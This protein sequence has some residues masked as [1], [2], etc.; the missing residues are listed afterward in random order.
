[1]TPTRSTT[2]NRTVPTARPVMKQ[3]A[4][5]AGVA[6]SSVS[7]VLNGHADV[8][9]VMRHRVLDAVAALGYEP[10]L[11]AQSLRTGAT[12][13]VGFVVG[14]ISNHL[15]AQIALGAEIS[16]REDGYSTL[17]TNS[18]NDSG[19][20]AANIRV[21]QQRRVDGLLLSLTDESDADVLAA[22]ERFQVP[23]V[24]VDRELDGRRF[25][26]VLSDHS[27]GIEA[28]AE[29]LAGLGHRTVG[30]VNGSPRVRPSRQRAEAL[31][32]V[33]R[34]TGMRPTVRSGS[35]TMEHGYSS[36]IELMEGPDA[37]SALI[38]GSNQ[39]LVGVLRALA[40]LGLVIPTDVSLV[41][42]DDV[43]LSAFLD[44]ALTA[45][46]RDPVEMG[47]VGAQLLV[48]LLHGGHQRVEV[49][50]TGFRATA[51]CGPPTPAV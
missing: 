31:R 48:E 19:R 26:A 23:G 33:C 34:R 24:L 27:T 14:D 28:A 35:F 44:P 3:V 17:L 36:T 13:S 43:P 39:I 46:S 32:R 12:M 7:R 16:L 38:A 47:R 49:L 25:S 5:R 11:L 45:I 37:P 10:D 18:V 2:G 40:H 50:P 1:M 51:S 4:D 30:L 9:D 8:S 6:V 21:L 29:H 20:D 42:C 15:I 41:T 22:L